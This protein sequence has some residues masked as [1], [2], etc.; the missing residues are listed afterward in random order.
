M[1]KQT[2]R[3]DIYRAW[4]E[5]RTA[6]LALSKVVHGSGIDLSLANLV[7]MRASQLNSCAFCLDM[8]SKDARALGETEQRIYALSAWRET[9]F[10][11]DKERAALALTEAVTLVAET[12]IPDDVM[13]EARH[14]FGD[15]ELAKLIFV[16]VTINSWNRIAIAAHL[17]VGNYQPRAAAHA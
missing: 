5:G 1:D 14:H 2:P 12:H 17:P 15:E 10:F 7:E 6:M 16:I 8:H 13:D 4:P 9:P 11:S 3:F